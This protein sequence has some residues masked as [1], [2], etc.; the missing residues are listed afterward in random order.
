EG[1]KK[2]GIALERIAEITSYQVAE[3]FNLSN[4]GRIEIGADAD[5]AIVDLNEE[6]TITPELLHSVSDYSVYEGMK[7]IGWPVYTI[8]RGETIVKNGEPTKE[9]GRGK[10]VERTI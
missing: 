3:S 9:Y 4:K 5:F 1:Y 6:K 7:T 2:R 10:Y 8:S